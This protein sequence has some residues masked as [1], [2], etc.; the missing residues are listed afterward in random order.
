MRSI[1]LFALAALS[2]TGPALAHDA[3][4]KAHYLGNEGVLIAHGDTKILFDAFYAN[5]YGEYLLVPDAISAAM[6]AGDA[7]YD[8]VDAIFV[9]H[10][11]GDHFTAAPAIAFLRAHEN[12]HL[13]GSKQVRDAM[14]SA[15]IP[16]DD[17]LAA[18]IHGYDLAP[19]DD[20]VVFN[21][22]DIAVDVV[23]IPHAGG[24]P[25]I[26]NFAWRVALDD[27]VTVMHLGDAGPVVSDF[28]RHAAHFD[29]RN[30][31]MAFP[32][33]W[34]IGHEDGEMILDDIIGADHVV[35][36]HV[37]ARAAGNGDEWRQRAGGD[38]FTDPGEMRDIG[39]N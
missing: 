1:F 17:P 23:A 7:P 8:G 33:Y 26:Q 6:M 30:T 9:S 24:R 5:S 19:E 11:H 29:A 32:P 16:E 31:H 3:E 10:V 14:I 38:L 21:I 39:G 22:G 2:L 25:T 20:A 27:G 34:F 4:A 37:P 35:G 12:V 13:Y 18:R 15:G 28:S 36:I